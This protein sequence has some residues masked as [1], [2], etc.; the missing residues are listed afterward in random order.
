MNVMNVIQMLKAQFSS[1]FKIT[2]LHTEFP[3]FVFISSVEYLCANLWASV[4]L[5]LSVLS[6]QRVRGWADGSVGCVGGDK[7]I[8]T[9]CEIV[10]WQYLIEYLKKSNV[11][12]VMVWKFYHLQSQSDYK[13]QQEHV[14]RDCD[15]WINFQLINISTVH[16]SL[17]LDI[18]L[19]LLDL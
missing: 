6:K 4:L 17:V 3:D 19:L 15:L 7:L 2:C 1:F 18:L 14:T 9:D 12:G 16:I 5:L 11:H 8:F 13:T 10:S